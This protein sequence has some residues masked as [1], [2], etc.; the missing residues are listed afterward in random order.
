MKNQWT[1]YLF[2]I[3]KVS[4]KGRGTERFLND[5]IRS[6]IAVWNVHR[7]EVDGLSFF[8]RLQDVHALRDV[9]RRNECKCRFEKRLGF[10]F[11]MKRSWR[12]N[13]FVMGF[14]AFFLLI[15]ILSNMI[16]GIEVDGASPETEHLIKKE[17]S[18]IGVTSG[19][20]QF[21][22]EN[23][24]DIQKTLTDNIQ[25]ITWVGVELTGT[26]YHLKV[27][28]KNQPE[29]EKLVS[30]RHIVAKKEAVIKKM[31]V[32][33]GQPM[34]TLN[35][36]VDKG[37]ILVSGL[38]GKEDDQKEVA[39]KAEIF[40]ETWYKSTI[41]IPLNTT[42]QV[43]TGNAKDKFYLKFGSF[44]LPIWGF[45]KSGFTSYELED[46][47]YDL[48]FLGFSLPLGFVKET[49]LEKE[50]VERKYTPK[51]AKKAALDR[52]RKDIEENLVEDEKVIGEKVLH[53]TKENGKV[54]LT[55]LY[56][57][58]ENI[59]KTTPIVQGD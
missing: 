42:F 34:T 58:L 26:T 20:F 16:W 14:L 44:K 48:K 53:E 59:V 27:V 55:V 1:S 39:A 2:G 15:F 7:S 3:L 50:E 11:L 40:G 29:E 10:P 41:S 25:Q 6:N 32:E 30:P 8:I 46:D 21:F 35:E 22:V 37:Q 24:D 33:Q 51:Q 17:L 43:L 56:Q 47:I 19:K 38:I 4:I 45:G 18:R 12:N 36:H 13:G 54:K 28:E 23:P 31:F 52:G 9:V 57:V 49:Y 5:C